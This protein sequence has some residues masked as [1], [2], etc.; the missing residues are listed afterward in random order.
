M[1]LSVEAKVL[2]GC[3]WSLLMT[4]EIKFQRPHIISKRARKG[5][6]ELVEKGF[7]T[8]EKFNNHSPALVWK[9]TEKMYSDQKPKVSRQFIIDNNFPLTTE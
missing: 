6:D 2:I 9:P 1:T 5:F 4:E 3:Y 7:L 8:V